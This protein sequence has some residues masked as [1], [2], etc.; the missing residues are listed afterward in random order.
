[1]KTSDTAL[2]AALLSLGFN[3][4]STEIINGK[5]TFI[6][7]S[8]PNLLAAENL[9]RTGSLMVNAL[10]YIGQY[11]SLLALVKSKNEQKAN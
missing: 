9:Y 2:A 7:P 8:D 10:V 6:F 1:M 5:T 11:K 4:E 3:Y